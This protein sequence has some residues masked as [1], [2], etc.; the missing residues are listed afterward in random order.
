MP[1][2][3]AKPYMLSALLILILGTGTLFI[4]TSTGHAAADLAERGGPIDAVLEAHEELASETR[5]LFAGLSVILTGMF[6]APKVL[7]REENR[8]FTTFLPMAFL[9][10]YS[11]G[12]LFLVNTAHA[13]GRLVHE[14]GVHAMIPSTSE[15]ALPSKDTVQTVET[16]EKR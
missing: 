15:G 6:F 13:G 11:V 4:A 5:I 1:P 10:L 3:R 16:A 2:S 7:R 9:A 12:V 8:L 14:F